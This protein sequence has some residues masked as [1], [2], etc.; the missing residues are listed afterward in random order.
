VLLPAPLKK[1][2]AFS[3]RRFCLETFC[4]SA[5]FGIVSNGRMEFNDAKKINKLNRFVKEQ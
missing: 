3:S 2:H 5:L 4:I 1:K